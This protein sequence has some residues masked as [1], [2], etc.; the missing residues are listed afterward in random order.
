MGDSDE[1]YRVAHLV[2]SVGPSSSG[3]DL[4]QSLNQY[5]EIEAV[6]ISLEEPSVAPENTRVIYP[7][8]SNSSFPLSRSR[9]LNKEIKN[10]DMVTCVH[11]F[12]GILGATVAKSQRKPVVAREGNNHRNFSRKVRAARFATGL[13][14]DRIVCVS[15]SVANSYHGFERII[16]D[17]KFAVIQNG[18]DIEE[19]Q[20]AKSCAWS[21]HSVADINQ[22]AEIV[23]TA[24]MFTEQKNHETLIRA[25]D[26][27][28]DERSMD[29]ELVIA[30]S[31][32]RRDLLAGLAR[33]LGIE[34]QV[35]FLGYLE[36]KQVYKML[37]EIDC[38]AMPSRWEGFSAAVLQAMAA[39]VPCVLSKIPS[40]RSQYP[41]SIV[42]F[43]DVESATDLA[44]AID[45][46]LEA[47]AGIGERGRE[48]VSENYSLESMAKKYEA[49]YLDML[50]RD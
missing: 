4:A 47:N 40:F 16:P 11:T 33:R 14:A 50:G 44:V 25:I 38:Y 10:V 22:D 29:V 45:A 17:S 15:Q 35:H 43:H 48:F 1:E 42:R 28:N 13:L 37:H 34:K 5:T 21:I 6:L 49:L 31:G 20:S 23:G 39:G 30:G 46:V 24:G 41:G 8:K 12:A 19:I 7:Q 32:P 9:W 2:N 18:V 27:L 26:R 3:G 36:R